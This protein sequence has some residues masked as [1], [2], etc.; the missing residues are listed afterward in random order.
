MKKESKKLI[1]SAWAYAKD[2][3]DRFLSWIKEHEVEGWIM[4]GTKPLPLDGMGDDLASEEVTFMRVHPDVQVTLSG[5]FIKDFQKINNIYRQYEAKLEEHLSTII[6]GT[7]RVRNWQ[8]NDNGSLT[9]STDDY[10]GD[11]GSTIIIRP[12]DLDDGTL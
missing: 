3:K 2:W 6:D 9:V 8:F 7:F 1:F 4:T 11:E 12:G 5:E 10:C